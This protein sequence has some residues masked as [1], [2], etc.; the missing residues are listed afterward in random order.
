MFSLVLFF[1]SFSNGLGSDPGKFAR[2]C[3]FNALDQQ[4]FNGKQKLQMTLP[5]PLHDVYTQ[6]CRM[7]GL[8]VR[9][10]R[11]CHWSLYRLRQHYFSETASG[12]CFFFSP[13]MSLRPIM[14]P[15]KAKKTPG[16]WVNF[17]ESKSPTA[18]NRNV[19]I[20]QKNYRS[21]CWGFFFFFFSLSLSLFL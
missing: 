16:N 19:F 13:V 20:E 14:G 18:E 15:F 21:A 5:L 3:H 1:S 2:C 17:P 12:N 6:F 9:K 11:F 10:L 8:H 4:H 7:C